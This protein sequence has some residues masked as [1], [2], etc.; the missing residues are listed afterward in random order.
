MITK[1]SK[2]AARLKRH[3]RVRA[4]LSGTA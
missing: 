1:T 2:N 4:K 3:A